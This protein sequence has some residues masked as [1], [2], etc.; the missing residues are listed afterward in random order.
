MDTNAPSFLIVPSSNLLVTRTAIKSQEEFEYQPY[1]ST[2]F[3]VTCP[4][5][6]EKNVVEAIAPP[7]L[8]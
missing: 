7:V 6:P 4:G 3:S 1:T 5:A 2:D 8:I